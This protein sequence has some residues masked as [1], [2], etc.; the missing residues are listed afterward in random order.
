VRRG[1]ASES[2]LVEHWS[3][4]HVQCDQHRSFGNDVYTYLV[5]LVPGINKDVFDNCIGNIDDTYIK[6]MNNQNLGNK[7]IILDCSKQSNNPIHDWFMD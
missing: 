5:L 7:G 4:H 2:F 3:C 1:C 6:N